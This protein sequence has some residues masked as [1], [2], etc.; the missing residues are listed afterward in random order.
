MEIQELIQEILGTTRKA[1][2][3][4]SSEELFFLD[5]IINQVQENYLPKEAQEFNQSI[6]YGKDVT[7]NYILDLSREFPFFGDRKLI[8]VKEAQEV[9]DWEPLVT[10]A[11][12]PLES[13]LLIICFSK[14]P[15][16]RSSWVKQVKSMD[17]YYEFKS[18]SDYQL[19]GFIKS[20]AKELDIKMDDEAQMLLVDYIGNDLATIQN[21][22]EKLKLNISKSHK[23]TKDDISRFIGVSKE[24]NV[25]ELQK[26]ISLKDH[27]KIFWI[28]SNMAHHSKTNPLI[29]TIAGLF[30]H[31]QKLWIAKI[32]GNLNDDDLNK[33]MKLPFKYFIKEYREAAQRF[34]I[35]NIELAINLLKEYDLKAKGMNHRNASDQDL[36]CELALK[37]NLL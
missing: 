37:I 1:I 33:I 28:C 34:S 4:I 24:F 14:K 3:V 11:K 8:I 21:E 13:T 25:F 2:Y 31:F 19:P 15:D 23:V 17:F 10:Y 12:K 20:T 36:Y 27:R 22:L 35:A 6:L 30:N 29:A 7:A 9:K 16:G 5:K 18:L 26:A 32:Y